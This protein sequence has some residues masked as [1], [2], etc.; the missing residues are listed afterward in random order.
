MSKSDV[1]IH[2]AD[3]PR[4]VRRCG[5]SSWESIPAQDR[6]GNGIGFCFLPVSIEKE[7]KELYFLPSPSSYRDISQSCR[8]WLRRCYT[9]VAL[10]VKKNFWQE[11]LQWL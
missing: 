11:S 7:E 5:R 9:G 6:S 2:T 10:C 4:Q 8:G 3:T 1:N